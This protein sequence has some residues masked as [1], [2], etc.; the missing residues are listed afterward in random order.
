MQKVTYLSEDHYLETGEKHRGP[1][2]ECWLVQQV[3]SHLAGGRRVAIINNSVRTAKV[4]FTENQF[5]S[6]T[7]AR[8]AATPKTPNSSLVAFGKYP[9]AAVVG[10]WL[11]HG[12]SAAGGLLSPF[13]SI[14]G[15]TFTPEEFLDLRDRLQRLKRSYARLPR[16]AAALENLNTG[17]FRFQSL[18]ESEAFLAEHLSGFLARARAL[19]KRY[20]LAVNGYARRSAVKRRRE[21]DRREEQ[22]TTVSEKITAA[23]AGKPRRRTLTA[24]REEWSAYLQTWHGRETDV[25]KLPAPA[26]LT[27]ERELLDQDRAQLNRELAAASLALSPVTADPALGDANTLGQ[28]ATELDLLIQE[29]DEAGI[30]QLP[31]AGASAATTTRQLQRLEGVLQQLSVTHRY[32][33]ELADF[34]AHRHLWY[35]Q[36]ARLRRLLAPLLDLPDADWEQAFSAWYF[37]R[38]LE[39]FADP[40]QLRTAELTDLVAMDQTVAEQS[41]LLTRLAPGAAVPPATQLLVDFTGGDRPAGYTGAFLSRRSLA[42]PEATHH[43]LAGQLDPRL[44]LLQEFV[45]RRPAAWSAV[46]V[47]GPPP[48]CN[49]QLSVQPA[50]DAP[51]QPLAEWTAAPVKHLRVYLPVRPQGPSAV[52]FLRTFD[53][54]LLLADRIT[55]HHAWAQNEITQA[56]LSDGLTAGSLSAILLRAAETCSETPFDHAALTALGREL[57]TR[58]GIAAP[59]RHPLAVALQPLLAERLPGFFFEVHQPW[60]DTFLPLVVLSPAGVKTVL[61]PGGRLPGQAGRHAEAA[62]QEALRTA[63]LHCLEIDARACWEDTAAEVQ[64]I[65]TFLQ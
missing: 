6:E 44:T 40:D 5:F 59:E 53:A 38:C 55:F 12:G 41:P 63:G 22:L 46:P 62:R 31:L 58:C 51:W 14:D 52:R 2:A 13:I 54:I 45:P 17:F 42:D 60:R 30:Y 23:T 26:E 27:A 50:D 56:L 4:L 57:R 43:A 32:L 47:T 11:Q 28:L 49:D 1:G 18:A 34:Y 39:Q 9:F 7:P 8:A 15:F 61:L 24:L 65:A 64:R 16:A 37:D 29:I 10:L 19:L 3:K 36:P 20:L 33:P 21:L 25:K 35:D 48:G